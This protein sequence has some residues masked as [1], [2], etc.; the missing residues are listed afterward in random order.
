MTA[1]DIDDRKAPHADACRRTDEIPGVIGAAVTDR[2]AHATQQRAGIG[3][4]PLDSG[5]AGYPAHRT[6]GFANR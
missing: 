6:R 3:S 5:E 2:V 1:G 4:V